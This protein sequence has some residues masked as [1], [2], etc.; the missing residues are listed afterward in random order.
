MIINHSDIKKLY[1]I[2]LG[3]LFFFGLSSTQAKSDRFP[4]FS[5]TEPTHHHFFSITQLF[6][7]GVING[8]SDGTFQA[9]KEVSRAEALKIILEGSKISTPQPRSNPFQDVPKNEWFAKYV[10]AAKQQGVISGDGNSN[11]FSPSRGV[12]KAE[13]VKMILKVNNISVRNNT[14]L[15]EW[16]EPYFE[17]ALSQGIIKNTQSPQYQL[18]RGDIVSLMYRVQYGAPP[19]QP[20]NTLIPQFSN[21]E[22]AFLFSGSQTKNIT[23]QQGNTTQSFTLSSGERINP[24]QLTAF[25]NGVLTFFESNNPNNK[26]GIAVYERFP[27]FV[28]DGVSISSFS[29]QYQSDITVSITSDLGSEKA[30]GYVLNTLEELYE[31]PVT[32]V[33]NTHTLSFSPQKKDFYVLEI[34]NQG[35]LALAILPISPQGYFPILPN[36]WDNN[37]ANSPLEQIN[38]LRSQNHLPKLQ[39]STT[40]NELAKV[41][42][43]DMIQRNYLGHTT[44]EG[45]TVNDIKSDF[46]LHLPIAENIALSSIGE[47]DAAY[48]LEY[49]PTHRNILLDPTLELVGINTQQDNTGNTILVELFQSK[50]TSTQEISQGIGTI[51]EWITEEYG[52]TQNNNLH[53]IATEWSQIMA[54]KNSTQTEFS[55]GSSWKNLLDSHDITT[56]TSIF[57]LSHQSPEKVLEHLQFNGIGASISSKTS[58]GIGISVHKNGI[59]YFTLIA[60]K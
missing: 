30:K 14:D 10:H 26:Y 52:L 21:G 16:Y 18:T 34:T 43:T 35:G 42:V 53:T 49:S 3:S 13:A 36:N 37:I 55:D 38:M 9:D 5:D 6:H 28:N 29:S 57:V 7:D 58:F 2:L 17:T 32:T 46:S 54:E 41:R 19:L 56:D 60:T 44:P 51:T 50:K 23:L 27:H 31:K 40:L 8:Y 11:L 25:D 1:I 4:F 15:E 45:D 48:F 20:N 39:E 24:S 22:I 59:V 12:N 47:I 33:E